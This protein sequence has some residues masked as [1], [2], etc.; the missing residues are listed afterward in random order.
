MNS[1]KHSNILS[2][3]NVAINYA[4]QIQS[5]RTLCHRCVYSLKGVLSPQ[6]H[7]ASRYMQWCFLNC[8][9]RADLGSNCGVRM[10]KLLPGRD[11]VFCR[12][13][14]WNWYSLLSH[15]LRNCVWLWKGV[16]LAAAASADDVVAIIANA[17]RVL[18]RR[19]KDCLM[20]L[21]QA[22]N[23]NLNRICL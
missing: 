6:L 10:A 15:R 8:S 9:V 14:G 2:C 7:R 23:C 19:W 18:E 3:W 22:T 1:K 12:Y 20:C 21:A 5:H 16:L 13:D 17:V 4:N 11:E